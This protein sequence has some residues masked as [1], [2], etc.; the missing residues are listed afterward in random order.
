MKKFL[1]TLTGIAT[2]GL[3]TEASPPAMAG[4]YLYINEDGDYEQTMSGLQH[5]ETFSVTLE[6]GEDPNAAREHYKH[7]LKQ[8]T[9]TKAC[10]DQY[11]ARSF[12]SLVCDQF[13]GC[14][15]FL[16]LASP[17][18]LIATAVMIHN[19]YEKYSKSETDFD[20]ATTQ[21][22]DIQNTYKHEVCQ[23]SRV[24]PGLYYSTEETDL[25]QITQVVLDNCTEHPITLKCGHL[26]STTPLT[27]MKE[28]QTVR[29]AVWG[30]CDET[31]TD[32]IVEK[33]KLQG[34]SESRLTLKNGRVFEV[35][36]R[37][38]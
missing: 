20:I 25:D 32:S 37:G 9:K 28:E 16:I 11:H 22:K 10:F 18:G 1:R 24:L 36:D 29:A 4:W 15:S 23:V 31:L 21:W 2:L 34:L 14:S 19:C 33:L 3:L 6:G 17:T 12:C 13:S 27:Q 26:N 8:F 5:K 35:N 30:D 38:R 7:A